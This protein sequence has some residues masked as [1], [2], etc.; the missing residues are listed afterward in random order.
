MRCKQLGIEAM[1]IAKCKMQN[2]KF[3]GSKNRPAF[4]LQFAV[5]ILQFSLFSLTLCGCDHPAKKSLSAPTTIAAAGS[6]TGII[7]GNVIL[8]G[9]PPTLAMIP[10]TGCGKGAT[11][12]PDESVV[13]D[14]DGHLQNVIVYL[15][16]TPPA[17]AAA[18]LPPVVLDQVNCHFVPH[19]LAVRTGQVL[20]ALSSDP[21]L[22]NVHGLC[23]VND[24]FNF[25][26]VA[27]GQSRDLRFSRPEI[28]PVRCDVHPWMKAYV[29]VF[30]HP[31]F[32]VTARNGRFEIKNVP[33]GQYTLTAWQET[34]GTLRMQVSAADGKVSAVGFKFSSGL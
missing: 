4:N 5:C 6:G 1:K 17:S 14:S 34:Y 18:D 26:L 2:A 12:L 16:N 3:E 19:V 7:R 20:R 21:T 15:E 10:N 13:V 25:G 11:P 28:F 29:G 23:T 27:A 9:R 31:W 30:E 33:A 24:P 22:H 32:A 8:T